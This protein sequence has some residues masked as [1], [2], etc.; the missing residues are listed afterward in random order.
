MN[1]II[2]LIDSDLSSLKE[3]KVIIEEDGKYEVVPVPSG[4][5]ALEY[6]AKNPPPAAVICDH[7]TCK[8][9]LVKSIKRFGIPVFVVTGWKEKTMVKLK[10]LDI[11]IIQK[12]FDVYEFLNFAAKEINGNS[13]PPKK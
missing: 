7:P 3:I 9:R 5:L 6:L 11:P 4:F 1:N 10:G 12:P 13:H 2:L 8:G